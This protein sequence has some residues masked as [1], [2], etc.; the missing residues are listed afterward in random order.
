MRKTSE[1]LMARNRLT[2]VEMMRL[3]LAEVRAGPPSPPLPPPPPPQQ[4]IQEY[5]RT[6]GKD[7]AGKSLHSCGQAGHS[8]NECPGKRG[9]VAAIQEHLV[10]LVTQVYAV[11]QQDIEKSP[12][13]IKG[14]IS[15]DGHDFD[16][17]FDSGATHSFTSSFVANGLNLPMYEFTSPMVAKTATGDLVSTSLM[18][19]E[20]KFSYEEKEY[21]VDLIVLEGMNLHIILSMDW[22][23][24]HGVMIDF[25][26]RK[27][28]FSTKHEK[29]DFPYLLVL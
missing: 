3:L 22:L 13:L 27:N 23:V 5:Y 1:D 7:T 19:K 29:K 26:S 15:V 2:N 21:V 18:C 20:V 12:N 11:T 16:A 25:C 28:Y 8:S 17:L 10:P 6:R 24:R 4:D 14:T 9:Q